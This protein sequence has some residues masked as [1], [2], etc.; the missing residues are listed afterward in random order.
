[1]KNLFNFILLF[2]VLL[3]LL[4][5][6][7]E[8]QRRMGRTGGYDQAWPLDSLNDTTN[9]VF[10]PLVFG[11]GDQYD[12]SYFGVADSISGTFEWTYTI[13]VALGTDI[14]D[15]AESDWIQKSTGS[16]SAEGDFILTYL[17]KE[18]QLSRVTFS[19]SGTQ[20]GTIRLFNSWR[21]RYY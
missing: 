18:G 15:V 8:S 21:R 17:H 1:M 7:A 19:S 9:L 4:P 2:S 3:M 13:D 10:Y 20:S 12:V 5:N 14:D 16:V 6:E 11:D